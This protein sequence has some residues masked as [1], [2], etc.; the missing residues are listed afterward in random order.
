MGATRRGT[1]GGAMR[2]RMST[3]LLLA[4]ACTQPQRPDGSLRTM[5]K[6]VEQANAGDPDATAAVVPRGKPLPWLGAPFGP[7]TP[8]QE[9]DRDGLVVQP[10]FTDTH[11]SAFVTTEIWD[12]F[13]RVWAQ[14]VYLLVTGF[15]AAG[16][17]R[18]L[19]GAFPIF[20]L[21]AD[22]R[23]YSPFWQTFYVTV[24]AGFAPDSLRSAQDVIASGLPLTPGPLRLWSI[25]PREMEVA[26]AS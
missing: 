19:A 22:A 21:D 14:P 15:D 12:G 16:G 25:G 20:G 17:P 18:A 7:G 6:L 4:A 10:A 5:S 9:A 2:L 23:F 1:E 11:P 3:A 8:L 13:P 26:H 24:P